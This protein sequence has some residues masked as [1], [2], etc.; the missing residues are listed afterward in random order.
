VSQ[1]EIVLGERARK[2]LDG[3]VHSD[4]KNRALFKI[5]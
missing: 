1:L 2:D 3:L 5:D 4:D